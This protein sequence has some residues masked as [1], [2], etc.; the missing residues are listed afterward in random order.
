MA[1]AEFDASR[2][3][4]D[5]GYDREHACWWARDHGREYR[6]TIELLIATDHSGVS[7]AAQIA[8]GAAARNSRLG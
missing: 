2:C 5:Y 4:G 6:F 1:L 3:E 8:A 7:I